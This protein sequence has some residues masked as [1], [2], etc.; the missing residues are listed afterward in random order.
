MYPQKVLQGIPDRERP[1]DLRILYLLVMPKCETK[2]VCHVLLSQTKRFP[3]N[4]QFF[5]HRNPLLL[6]FLLINTKGV[7]LCSQRD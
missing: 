6:F 7:I 3:G 4:L 1:V 2:P 5:S